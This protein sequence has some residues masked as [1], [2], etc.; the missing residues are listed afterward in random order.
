MRKDMQDLIYYLMFKVDLMFIYGI[1]MQHRAIIIWTTLQQQVLEQLH[2]NQMCSKKT[3]ILA[4]ESICKLNMS[5]DI[6]DIIE[7]MHH[8]L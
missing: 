8:M 7:K 5:N 4:R 1:A 6:K 2:V 3:R